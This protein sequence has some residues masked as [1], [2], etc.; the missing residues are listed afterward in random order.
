[1]TMTPSLRKFALT[2][3]V[4]SSV[5]L[6]GSIAAFV[7]L[8]VAG[9]TS[10][11]AQI[12]RA[13]YLAMDLTTRFVIVPLAFASLLT[14][15]IQS[16]GT[17]WGLFRHYWVLAKLL[18]TVFATIVLLLKMELVSYAARLATETI[19]SRADLRAA[20]IELAVHAAG[21]LLVL[22]V[23]AILSVYKP[24]GLTPYGQ[25]KPHEHRAPSQQPP[26][27][28][29]SLDSNGDIGVWPLGGS[30]TIT[31]RRAHMYGIIVIVLVLHFVI[32]H[33]AGI[34]LVGH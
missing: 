14:G 11:D 17:P 7:A 9:L 33:L 29:P 12:V 10:E 4:T 25:R 21:G 3:H 5:G 34:G 32:L 19:L 15:L 2:A 20:G 27:Q 23:P 18:L 16:L 30:I 31:L 22:L 28:R 6:L 1:M 24:R 26:S 8:A 13:A